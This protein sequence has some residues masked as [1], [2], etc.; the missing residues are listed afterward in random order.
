[1]VLGLMPLGSV[2]LE[3]AWPAGVGL[4][5]APSLIVGTLLCLQ[6]FR[7]AQQLRLPQ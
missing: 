3:V 4:V 1:M 2:A 7:W 6:D 5:L